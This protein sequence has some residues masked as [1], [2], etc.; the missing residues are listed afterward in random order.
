MQRGYFSSEWL[1]TKNPSVSK[2]NAAGVFL[3]EW[4]LTKN[5]SVAN[6]MQ[7][8]YF[9]S[10]WL[11]QKPAREIPPVFHLVQL[12]SLTKNASV[13]KCNAAGVFL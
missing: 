8:E 12:H 9:S 2:C 1:L 10:E 5:A 7:R 13:S 6:V 3:S 4:L 11:C